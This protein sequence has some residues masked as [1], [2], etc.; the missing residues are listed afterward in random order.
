MGVALAGEAL[1]DACHGF[2]QRRERLD[3]VA[4]SMMLR[5]GASAAALGAALWITRR[6]V[7]AVAALAVARLAVALLYDRPRAAVGQGRGNDGWR[8][9]WPVFRTAL[10]LGVV[11]MLVSLNT[12]VPRYAIERWLGAGELGAFAAVASFVQAGAVAVQALGQTA[13]PRLAR[14]F[15]EG[16]LGSFRRL[17]RRIAL[18]GL[19]VGAAGV[20]GAA[21]FGSVILRLLYRPEYAAYS[22]LFVKVMAEAALGYVAVMLGYALTSARS[23][24]PQAP[25]LAAAVAVSAVASWALIPTMGLDGAAAAMALAACVQIAGSLGILHGLERRHAS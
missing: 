13:T 19:G 6:L 25:L 2:L 5:A 18:L 15:A 3:V 11:L 21:V 17:G 10:P 4:R 20:A 14:Y 16:D 22:G 1:S 12:N 7:W 9:G 24:R 8:E 23:F